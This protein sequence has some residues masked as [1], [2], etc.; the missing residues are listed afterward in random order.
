MRQFRHTVLALA[1]LA[2]ACG[3]TAPTSTTQGSTGALNPE[4]APP[5][6]TTTA[7]ATVEAPPLGGTSWEIVEYKL[8]S[9][10]LTNVWKTEVT[11]SFAEDG[12]VSGNSGCNDFQGT[13]SVSGQ[14]DVFE[15][16][17]PDPNDGQILTLGSLNSTKTACEDEA[18]MEQEGEI[19]D[20]LGRAGRWVLIRGDFHLR[21]SEGEYLLRAEPG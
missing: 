12:T 2:A 9:G 3:G 14:W 20:I 13:W 1:V 17:V 19:L 4:P 16:G 18:I 6:P 11:I 5:D 7:A 15:D 8:P 10:S 21:D